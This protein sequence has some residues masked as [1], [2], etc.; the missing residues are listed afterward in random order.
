MILRRVVVVGLVVLHSSVL[1]EEEKG[2]AWNARPRS[3]NGNYQ[4]YG[5]TLSEM[6]PPNRR[7]RK[8]SFMFKGPL[9][10]EL[11]D[12]LGPDLKAS[13]SDA[14]GYRERTRGDLSCTFTKEDGFTCYLGLDA[15]TG[16][17]TNGA[18]C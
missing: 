10:K 8:V 2:G 14:P 7:D 18:I 9:A 11:F 15:V 4:V 5:G 3:L 16:R 6:I 13:C 12:Q 1:A 17:S